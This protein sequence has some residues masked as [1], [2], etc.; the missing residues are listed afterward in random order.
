MPERK[1]TV[2]WVLILSIVCGLIV[3]HVIHWHSAGMYLEMFKWLQTGK[4][5][6]TV[7][8]NLGLMLVLGAV[9]GLLMQ[10]ITDLF[11]YKVHEIQHFKGERIDKNK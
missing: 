3:W 7:L 1:T 8:Y 9:L 2:I 6:I 5:Y 4:G 11:G 10:K